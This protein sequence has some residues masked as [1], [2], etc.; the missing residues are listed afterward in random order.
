MARGRNWMVAVVA[1]LTLW[2]PIQAIAQVAQLDPWTALSSTAPGVP[3]I[4]TAPVN[5]TVSAGPKRI[6]LVAAVLETGTAGTLTSFNATLG[7]EALTPLASTETTSGRETVKVWRM[8]HAQIPAGFRTS[9]RDRNPHSE[10]SRPAPLLGLILL[11][12]PGQSRVRLG[13]RL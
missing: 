12:R 10:R 1:M 5:I 3:T 7:G 11:C 13:C 9:R 2:T 4:N 8:S 6:L